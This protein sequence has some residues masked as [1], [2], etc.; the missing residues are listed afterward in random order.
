MRK[1]QIRNLEFNFFSNFGKNYLTVDYTRS[2]ERNHITY[3]VDSNMSRSE[4][5]VRRFLNS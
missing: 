5:S 1:S 2:G 3:I 4:K